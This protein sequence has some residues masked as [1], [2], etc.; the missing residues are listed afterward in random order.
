MKPINLLLD[1]MY[2]NLIKDLKS[3]EF[4]YRDG[5]FYRDIVISVFDWDESE[6]DI[7]VDNFI[8]CII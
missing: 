6:D 7:H 2:Y 1:S 3:N 5:I 4:I 8:V